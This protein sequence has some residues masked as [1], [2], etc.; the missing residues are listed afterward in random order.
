[1]DKSQGSAVLVRPEV[2][3]PA[4]RTGQYSFPQH[5][6]LTD[7]C[8]DLISRMLCVDVAKRITVADIQ[9]RFAPAT[10]N[11]FLFLCHFVCCAVSCLYACHPSSAVRIF[12]PLAFHL[13]KPGVLWQNPSPSCS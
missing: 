1:M 7:E 12:L 10:S 5:V 9:V 6:K 11:L 13:N 3:F 4:L 8:K 2:C